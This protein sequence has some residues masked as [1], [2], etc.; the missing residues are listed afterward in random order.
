MNRPLLSL[1]A[2]TCLATSSC[3]GEPEAQASPA[4]DAA[5]T[6]DSTD[7]V[8]VDSGTIATGPLLSGSLQPREQATVRAEVGGT[9]EQVLVEPGD[10]VRR[11][12][13]LLRLDA[14][15]PSQNLASAQ[16]RERSAENQVA[17]ARRNVERMEH[18]VDEGAVAERDLEDARTALSSAQAALAEA[19]AGLTQAEKEVDDTRPE[20]PFDGVVSRRPVNAG[21]VVSPG[22]ELA[23]V[24]DPFSLRLVAA[25]PTES[26][27]RV[28]VGSSVAFTV[29]GYPARRFTGTVQNI[30][31]AADPATRQ[32]TLYVAIPNKER[33]LVAG[34]YAEGRVTTDSRRALVVP[35]SAT[36]LQPGEDEESGTVLRVD[37]G[38]VE[39]VDADFGV[40]DDRTDRIEVRSGLQA[41]DTILI[42]PARELTPG[43][44]VRDAGTTGSG[45]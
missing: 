15:A 22:T 5:V 20:A 11:G 27:S 9:V 14:D 8:V 44:P 40:L 35:R 24:I 43:T 45:G 19:K 28:K 10:A 26:L 37:Q 39:A 29:T 41:G 6:I 12:Q 21:D 42:G 13:P 23:V 30:A 3:G 18:L 31:P 4:R 2:L 25:V 34:V 17:V 38:R 7:V 32:I 36:D 1:L 16:A 33:D